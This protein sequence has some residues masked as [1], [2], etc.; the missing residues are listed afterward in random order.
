MEPFFDESNWAWNTLPLI[1]S[2]VSLY[3][4]WLWPAAFVAFSFSGFDTLIWLILAFFTSVMSIS[5]SELKLHYPFAFRT[6][7]Q[8]SLLMGLALTWPSSKTEI[9]PN[10]A[11]AGLPFLL[12]LPLSKWLQQ[13]SGG[14][15]FLTPFLWLSWLF[16][17]MQGSHL[18]DAS[19]VLGC[20]LI[21][22]MLLMAWYRQIP[23]VIKF[24]L[25]CS[26][27]VASIWVL[28]NHFNLT[29]VLFGFLL[30]K[31]LDKWSWSRSFC[32][33]NFG[34][35]IQACLV[36]LALIL[37]EAQNNLNL[38]H[39]CFACGLMFM[40]SQEVCRLCIAS[41]K[42]REIV[43]NWWVAKLPL[44]YLLLILTGYSAGLEVFLILCFTALSQELT[45]DLALKPIK[46]EDLAENP[47]KEDFA[48]FLN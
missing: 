15:L 7:M 5:K 37:G 11:L 12:I 2:L 46:I 31:L 21:Y 4:S 3:F 32:M 19:V 20:M 48:V 9:F 22:L 41:A 25:L 36:V 28:G 44:L 47:C 8:M 23:M 16:I 40:S 30:H 39:L 43:L 10:F 14:S 35:W 6:W 34:V 24:L 1:L 18:S 33:L 45:K 42:C 27:M 13:N 26:A 29:I 17:F 38:M